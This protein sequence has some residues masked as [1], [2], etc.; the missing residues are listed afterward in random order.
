VSG[1]LLVVVSGPSGVGKT[2]VVERLLEASDYERAVTATTREPR[3][4]EVDGVDYEFL[5]REQFEARVEEGGFLEHA[6]VHGNR[7]GTPKANVER[8]LGRGGVCIL[9]VDV[10][11]AAS[12]RGMVSPAMDVFLLPPDDA[13]LE[14]RLRGRGTDDAKT[15]EGRLETARDELARQGEYEVTV[16]ND[17]LERCVAELAAVIE[18]R[19]GTSEGD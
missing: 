19:R 1:G 5:T 4:A 7:Y 8:I 3:G 13:A 17:D 6:R 9:N 12:I 16:V 11:G 15:V 2:T 10:Q 14:A 18:E